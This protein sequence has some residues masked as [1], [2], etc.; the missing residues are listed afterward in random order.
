LLG[1]IN[2]DDAAAAGWSNADPVF[3]PE[4]VDEVEMTVSGGVSRKV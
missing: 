3:V 2:A 4:W 1:S